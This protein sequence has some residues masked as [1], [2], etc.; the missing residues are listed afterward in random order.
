MLDECFLEPQ[1]VDLGYKTLL[2]KHVDPSW[3]LSKPEREYR[4]AAYD[5]GGVTGWCFAVIDRWA[6]TKPD[7]KILDNVCFWSA[8]EWTGPEA[9]QAYAAASLSKE[10]CA[11]T[12]IED[13]ILRTMSGGRELLA[14]VRVTAGI[15]QELWSPDGGSHVIRQQP[16]LAMTT[17]TD[18]RLREQG[19]WVPGMPHA[20]D[21]TRHLFTWLRRKKALLA[22]GKGRT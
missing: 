18:L 13:F 9:R 2:P 6:L 19:L 22:S 14:P 20:N 10:W 1:G 21:A 4:V 3:R 12:V 5:P 16:S 8:G 15:E 11:V 7:W 17:M